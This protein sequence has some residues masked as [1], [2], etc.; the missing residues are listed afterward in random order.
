MTFVLNRFKIYN[1]KCIPNCL[2]YKSWIKW[3]RWKNS[4]ESRTKFH[5]RKQHFTPKQHL[6]RSNIQ[7][8]QEWNI[9]RKR[10]V[11]EERDI[12]AAI[13]PLYPLVLRAFQCPAARIKASHL[14]WM[15]A[16]DPHRTSEPWPLHRDHQPTGCL[17]RNKNSTLRGRTCPITVHAQHTASSFP[18]L[19]L[20]RLRT[21]R[22]TNRRVNQF[23]LH[24][25]NELWKRIDRS[26]R[27]AC[28]VAAFS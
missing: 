9:L 14:I 3:N 2:Y 17:E 1:A 16:E 13:E 6:H 27:S 26:L 25:S 10:I 5:L 12:F 21:S 22:I 18:R 28:V 8:I 11:A 19:I 7:R 23:P 4:I 15:C 20:F 24:L